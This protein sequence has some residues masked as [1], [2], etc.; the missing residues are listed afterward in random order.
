MKIDHIVPPH[1]RALDA[2]PPGKPIEELEREL[3]I[4]DSIKLA[5][6]ENPLGAS[7]KALTAIRSVLA[8]INRYPDGGGF[9]LRRALASHFGISPTGVVIGNGSNELIELAV[10]TFLQPGDEAV[11]AE[12]A[13]AIYHLVVQAHGARFTQVP[14]RNY[15]HDL[16][17]IADAL[18]PSTRMVFLANPNNPTGTIF[19]KSEWEDFLSA[20]SE[21]TIIVMD[22]AY[23]E[24]VGDPRYPDSL[25]A[26][27]EGRPII[28]LRTFSKAYG[29]AGLRVGYALT[30]PELADMMDR[31][32]APFNVNLLSQAAA[33]AAL[34]DD[35][36][37]QRTREINDEGLRFLCDALR[38]RGIEF[39]PSWANFLMVRVGHGRRVYDSLLRQGVI[40]RPMDF[41]GFPE[42]VRITIGLASE[43]ERLLQALDCTLA[44]EGA[45]SAAV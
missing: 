27:R 42:F 2:Y 35:E 28:I 16:H 30:L 34:D 25:A 38:S 19:F 21:N 41:Y 11:M 4:T 24:F 43:N 14:L 18:R 7:P 23:A 20:V 44:G 1:I 45:S 5:S 15:T 10:R 22:E 29:L 39:V 40:V 31:V 9:Y 37:V 8:G 36:H 17:A 32:R 3:G 12:Q 26:L 33:L 13:F 6:N